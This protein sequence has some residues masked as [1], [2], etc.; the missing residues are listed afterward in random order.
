MKNLLHLILALLLFSSCTSRVQ[1]KDPTV[2]VVFSDDDLYNP[3]VDSSNGDSIVVVERYKAGSDFKEMEK[4]D[5][6]T[7]MPFYTDQFFELS[8]IYSD[9]YSG[10]YLLTKIPSGKKHYIT[11]LVTSN[12]SI[13]CDGSYCHECYNDVSFTLN[14][15]T[16][17]QTG[18]E[19][20]ESV[21]LYIPR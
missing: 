7:I 8:K 5:T 20:S 2:R 18:G 21:S 19:W 9:V 11:D 12:R 1:C 17:K 16:P 13:R 6:A 3:V 10:D 15:Q 14:K 4:L